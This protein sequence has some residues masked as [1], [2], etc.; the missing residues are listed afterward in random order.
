MVKLRTILVSLIGLI[1]IIMT[2]GCN[3]SRD[4]IGQFDNY[5]K[6]GQYDQALAFSEAR[7]SKAKNGQGNDLLWC[8]NAATIYRLKQQPEK[9]NLYFDY[10]E[11]ILNKHE[12]DR[13]KLGETAG[14]AILNENIVAYTGKSYD[15]I[16]VNVYK[17]LNF[18]QMGRYDLAR[19]EFNRAMDRQR[20]AVEYYNNEVQRLQSE[21]DKKNRENKNAGKID[22]S[23]YKSVVSRY[24]PNLD[25]YEV[26]SDF[27]N[28]FANYLAGLFFYLEGD[29]SK[30]VDLMKEAAGMI[31]DNQYVISDLRMVE[32][33]AFE[34][35]A[36][37][38]NVWVIFENGLGPVRRELRFAL[39]IPISGE[40]VYVD[41][42]MP[43]LVDRSIASR[44]LTV[45]SDLKKTTSYEIASMDRVIQTEFQKEF[46]L[47]LTRA[48]AGA[49]TKA[50]LQYSMRDQDPM[51]RLA[52][53]AYT[54]VSTSAD[55]RIWSSL[56]KNFQVAKVAMP[57]DG[58]VHITIPG[59]EIKTIELGN[60]KNAII[61]VKLPVTAGVPVYDVMRFDR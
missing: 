16:M 54:V 5:Y 6:R 40:L 25:R 45:E 35:Q 44:N 43:E 17:A 30:S 39:P 19:V 47:S 21:V 3:P 53:L 38:S 26:Y 7:I 18:I 58:K 29:Y 10:A 50:V 28:P 48:I 60:C 61:Y 34:N 15:G 49:T 8:L 56:P 41:V 1:F 11:A 12:A 23:N 31:S 27:V 4:S 37:G 51:V 46:A 20:R 36:R 2:C 32:S 14:A 33:V 9:S 55:V 42:A 57:T 24:Y 59:N 13:N 52:A 22:N